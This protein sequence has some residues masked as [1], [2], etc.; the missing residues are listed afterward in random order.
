M[1]GLSN[2][3]CSIELVLELVLET[4]VTI[5][6]WHQSCFA[7]QYSFSE[8]V[9]SVGPRF[10]ETLHRAPHSVKVGREVNIEKG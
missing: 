5:C 2:L 3:V 4:V 6:L 7:R 10:H 1:V 8:S 9:S